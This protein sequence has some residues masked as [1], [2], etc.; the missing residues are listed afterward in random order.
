MKALKYFGL[1]AAVGMTAISCQQPSANLTVLTGSISEDEGP[2]IFS[3]IDAT[4][5]APVTLDTLELVD[6]KFEFSWEVDSVNFYTFLSGKQYYIPLLIEPGQNIQL[7]ISGE[8]ADRNYTVSGSPGSDRIH[9]INEVNLYAL[10]RVDSLN[11]V[12]DTYKDSASYGF[13]KQQLDKTFQ[14]ILNE[15]ELGLKKFIDEN[16]GDLSNLMTFSQSVGRQ[17]LLPAQGDNLVYYDKVGEALQ[18]KYPNNQH[19]KF[20]LR[21]MERTKQAEE[22]RLKMLEAKAK[23]APGQPMPDFQLMTPDGELRALSDLR[24]KVV[25]VDFWA[26]WCRPCRMEN[27]NLV[28]LYA[29]YKDKGFDVFSVSL[30]GLPNQPN[31]RQE[32]LGAIQQDALSWPNHVSDLKGW[33]SQVVPQFGIQGIPFTVLIDRDGNILGTDLRGNALR[34]KVKSILGA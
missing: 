8:G 9:Q 26:S 1:L 23:L 31:P 16:P 7:D 17:Q 24:G 22:M 27:P 30:D 13:I 25:L 18:E 32:W 15:A 2:I 29:D 34:A 21:T 19:T 12:A 14:R 3:Y 20:F 11:T 6:G 4:K 10:K 28:K 33:T 5:K